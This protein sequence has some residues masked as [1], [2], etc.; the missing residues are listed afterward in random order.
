MNRWF[1]LAVASLVFFPAMVGSAT[2]DQLRDFGRGS[3]SQIL[4]AHA[5]RPTVVHFWGV[6]CGPCKTEMPQWGGLL[7]ERPDL[8]LVLIDA[9]LVPNEPRVIVAMLEEA[10]LGGVESWTFVDGFV[11]RLRYEV[12]PQWRGEIP[13]NVL[14]ARD[15]AT[16]VIEG[17]VDGNEIKRWL[18]GQVSRPK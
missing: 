16:R 9:D 1:W 10:G 7:R 11:E 4:R 18:D 12:D 14:I 17:V 15:G 6:T 2:L 8:E 3:W 5:G 13:R